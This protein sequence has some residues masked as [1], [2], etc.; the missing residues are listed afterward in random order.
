MYTHT[1]TYA[2]MKKANIY[3]HVSIYLS[4]IDHALYYCIVLLF[5]YCIVHILLF[6]VH[7]LFV[8]K[9]FLINYVVN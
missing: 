2:Y 6:I 5:M 8:H 7:V 1:Y 9:L 4:I 3:L